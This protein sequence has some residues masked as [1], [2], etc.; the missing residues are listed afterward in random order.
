MVLLADA[1]SVNELIHQKMGIFPLGINKG[2]DQLAYQFSLIG[3]TAVLIEPHYEN[4][5]LQGFQPDRTQ[6]GL[7]NHRRLL[8]A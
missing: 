5:C 6:T 7:Y 2:V 1:A 8:R 4:V 3:T